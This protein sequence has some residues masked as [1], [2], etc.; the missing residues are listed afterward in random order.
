MVLKLY[1]PKHQ[2]LDNQ[3]KNKD[4]DKDKARTRCKQ[5]AAIL[6]PLNDMQ[7]DK[8]KLSD[9]CQGNPCN[10]Q[11]CCVRR[12]NNQDKNRDKDKDKARTRCKQE[13]AILCPLNDNDLDKWKIND[14]CGPSNPQDCCMR[15]G[16]NEETKQEGENI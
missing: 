6:C 14:K 10:P 15:R 8:G 1:K 13:A 11:E 4:K 3:D 7:I 16:S 12:G 2:T 9:Q 5:E